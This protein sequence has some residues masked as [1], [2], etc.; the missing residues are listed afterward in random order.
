MFWGVED[1]LVYCMLLEGLLDISSRVPRDGLRHWW[2]TTT[3]N[4][5]LSWRSECKICWGL[6]III[7]CD[8]PLFLRDIYK[9]ISVC[10]GNAEIDSW[11]SIMSSLIYFQKSMGSINMMLRKALQQQWVY[12]LPPSRMIAVARRRGN[13]IS[14][15]QCINVHYK[16]WTLSIC[17]IT[18][19][20]W[21]DVTNMTFALLTSWALGMVFWEHYGPDVCGG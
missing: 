16:A 18:I 19:H 5:E 14:R 2:R 17:L 4:S 20:T 7:G 12:H 15:T 1:Q 9:S 6:G 21:Y 10:K 3:A 11:N 13:P 8:W